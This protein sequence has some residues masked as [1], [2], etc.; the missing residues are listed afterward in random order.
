MSNINT[1]SILNQIERISSAAA[2]CSL[3][4]DKLTAA[5]EDIEG[6]RNSWK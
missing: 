5:R 4:F 6:Y 2:K 3:D 1:Q